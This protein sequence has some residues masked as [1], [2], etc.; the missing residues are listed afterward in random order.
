VRTGQSYL[1]NNQDIEQAMNQGHKNL[2]PGTHPGAAERLR[3]IQARKALG[4]TRAE[5][6]KLLDRLA[7]SKDT[8]PTAAVAACVAILNALPPE[9]AT[10]TAIT[11]PPWSRPADPEQK[12]G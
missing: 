11:A 7:R 10:V 2:Q 9:Q 6:L 1:R 5:T 3:R 12:T 4:P 8:N